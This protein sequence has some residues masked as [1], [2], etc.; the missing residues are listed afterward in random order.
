MVKKGPNTIL[1]TKVSGAKGKPQK[2]RIGQE[3]SDK[4]SCVTKNEQSQ[5]QARCKKVLKTAR[6][7]YRPKPNNNL[8]K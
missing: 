6:F 4:Q 1:P 2:S 5:D 3:Q 7:M 8:A